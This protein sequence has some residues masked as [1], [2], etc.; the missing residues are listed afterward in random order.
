M[1]Q[2]EN[3]LGFI[4]PTVFG[5]LDPGTT[6][7]QEEFSGPALSVVMADNVEEAVTLARGVRHGL[8]SS[9]HTKNLERAM[10]L[11]RGKGRGKPR[12]MLS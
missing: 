11:L 2:R 10:S 5:E 8:A 1:R 4:D 3:I 12:N 9:I 7:A 6:I